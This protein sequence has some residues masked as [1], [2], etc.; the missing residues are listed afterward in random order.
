MHFLCFAVVYML[1]FRTE[2]HPS[3]IGCSLN[4]GHIPCI[5]KAITPWKYLVVS[6]SSPSGPE[7]EIFISG[8]TCGPSLFRTQRLLKSE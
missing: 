7:P 2:Q 4:T 8:P 3:G 1:G 6:E 5:C